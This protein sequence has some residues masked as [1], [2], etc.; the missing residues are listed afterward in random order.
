MIDVQHEI[1][2]DHFRVAIFGSAR[3]QKDDERYQEI[4]ELAGLIG[5]RGLDIVTGGGPGLMEAANAGHEAG[6]RKNGNKSHSIGLTIQLPREQEDNKHLDI[7][8]DFVR[9]SAR[10]DRFMSL[11][12]V[13]VVA[14]G[15]IGTALELFYTWQLIQVKHICNIPIILLGDMWPGLIEWVKKNPLK[16]KLMS[17]KDI[18]PIFLVNECEQAMQIIDHTYQAFKEG[19]GSF[20]VNSKKY[21][22]K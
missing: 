9:F 22:L 18:N 14:P 10:L 20:C 16:N 4:F 21:K 5:A 7:K 17:Q 13:V 6:K 8:Q 11:S 19:Q 12:N 1:N 15:G 3:I 2:E